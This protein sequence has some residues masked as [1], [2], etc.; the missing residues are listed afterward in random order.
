MRRDR[1][2]GPQLESS[3]RRVLYGRTGALRATAESR[4]TDRTALDARI[5]RITA[6]LRHG[7][8]DISADELR[9]AL[10]GAEAKRGALLSA[11]RSVGG[12]YRLA[13]E[14]GELVAYFGLNRQPL[15][16]AAGGI[17]TGGSGGLICP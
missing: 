3:S 13:P 10:D 14:N 5:T 6:R 1:D 9:A 17:G 12:T 11:S 15:L 4:S 8:P 16:R 2:S 7:D